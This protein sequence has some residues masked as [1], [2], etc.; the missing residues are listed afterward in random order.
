MAVF[1]LLRD[2]VVH[3]D[4]GPELANH[5]PPTI[6]CLT[7]FPS[8]GKSLHAQRLCERF[9]GFRVVVVDDIISDDPLPG[10][11]EAVMDDWPRTLQQAQDFERDSKRDIFVLLYYDMPE[12]EFNKRRRDAG[13]ADE[14]RQRRQELEPLVKEFRKRGNIL[15]ISAQWP[16]VEEVWEQVEA[17]VEQVLELRDRGERVRVE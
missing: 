3:A 12:E 7:G 4:A 14:Y 6:I 1:S 2:P 9:E 5:P 17:K 11:R 10:V 15:E 16:D 8:T 13:S